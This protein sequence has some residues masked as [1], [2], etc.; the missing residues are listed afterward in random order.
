MVDVQ[1]STRLVGKRPVA[2][3]FR[4]RPEVGRLT[5]RCSKLNHR[6]AVASRSSFSAGLLS[7]GRY[8][9]CAPIFMVLFAIG[10]SSTR[11]KFAPAPSEMTQPADLYDQD[12]TGEL[13]SF[14]DPLKCLMTWRLGFRDVAS[15]QVVFAELRPEHP[16]FREG[17]GLETCEAIR[18][19]LRTQVPLHAPLFRVRISSPHG[20]W[21]GTMIR[22]ERLQGG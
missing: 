15:G 9:S 14:G 2:P 1:E 19:F 5:M 18:E 11:A 7:L 10:C 4:R 20:T 17:L 3:S 16:F 21:S 22:W 8:A 12:F 13:V 6:I